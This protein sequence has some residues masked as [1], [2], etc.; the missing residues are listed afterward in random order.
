VISPEP[1]TTTTSAPLVAGME[2]RRIVVVVVHE[3]HDAIEAADDRHPTE[4]E[5]EVAPHSAQ[6][7]RATE[8]CD[9]PGTVQRLSD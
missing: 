5:G 1:K 6:E 4:I 7:D 2:M 3:D 8:G 9:R